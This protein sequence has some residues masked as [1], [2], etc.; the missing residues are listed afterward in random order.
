MSSKMTS[1]THPLRIDSVA[2]PGMEGIIGMTFCPGKKGRGL[3]SGEWDRDLE[4][5]LKVIKDWGAEAIVS[6][7]E[8]KEFLMMHVPDFIN[9]VPRHG[10][11]EYHLPIVDGQIPD[12]KFEHRWRTAGPRLRQFLRNGKKI[13]VHCKGGLGRT[14]TIAARLL[15]EL[16]V[17]PKE[18]IMQVRNARPGAIET[19][20][21]AHYVLSCKPLKDKRNYEHF[22]G[23]MLGGAVGDALGAPVEFLAM[24]EL[25]KRYGEHGIAD[26]GEC[27]GRKGAITDDTQ[28]TLFTAEGLLRAECRVHYR[29]IGPAFRPVV[30]HAYQRWLHSQ[31]VV[32]P[33]DFCRGKEDGWLINIPE[34]HQ[35]RAP[36]STC[37]SALQ[38]G[39]W[40]TVKS[41]LNNSKGCGGVM[42][43]APVGLYAEAKFPYPDREISAHEIF[44]LGCDLASITHFHPSGFLPAG[45]LAIIISDIISGNSLMNSIKNA[46]SILKERPGNEET[47][48]ALNYALQMSGDK[49]IQ[50]GPE[51]INKIGEGWVAE[52]A[53]AI[54]CYCALVAG[55]NFARGV[56]LAVNHDGDSDSTGAIT[57]NILG[58]LLGIGAIPKQ[59]IEGLELHDVIAEIARDLLLV[60]EKGD[61]WLMK[62]PEW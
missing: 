18:A 9:M 41:P 20:S 59:W 61:A 45:C 39:A 34:L 35:R 24:R 33:D 7:M 32:S 13:V 22:A 54:S 55:N 27:F 4:T 48:E 58:A 11:I 57:G 42:R 36:G 30:Y 19:D 6:L 40:N 3:Y 50:P 51:T 15:V 37:L 31:G 38:E 14:G 17:S 62:Y 23:C 16:G 21:Q 44:D 8:E 2:V 10:L 28:M 5:D 1:I 53:L 46:I 60:F 56:R 43:V 47:L 29:G 52:E 12:E 26:Y 25:R 49:K